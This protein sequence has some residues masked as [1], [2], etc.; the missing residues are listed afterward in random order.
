MN[1]VLYTFGNILIISLFVYFIYAEFK[2]YEEINF[3]EHKWIILMYIVLLIIAI[4]L[5][6]IIY[7]I[8]KDNLSS[9]IE[10]NQLI[11]RVKNG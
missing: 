4:I 2:D 3:Y 6:R 7:L 9:I 10:Y 5:W 1:N 11:K 8:I